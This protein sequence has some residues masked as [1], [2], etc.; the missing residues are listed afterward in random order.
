MY[1]PNLS[2]PQ[3]EQESSRWLFLSLWFEIQKVLSYCELAW[4]CGN[5]Y[6]SKPLNNYSTTLMAW[7]E[8]WCWTRHYCVDRSE[9]HC[10]QINQRFRDVTVT[11]QATQ[12]GFLWTPTVTDT[13]FWSR[14]HHPSLAPLGLNS[15]WRVGL[16]WDK[17]GM[18]GLLARK[19]RWRRI[20]R[21][22]RSARTLEANT[23][24][25][26]PRLWIFISQ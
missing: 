5:Q 10:K 14:G 23:E 2:R 3:L 1:V 18:G 16:G 25:R 21:M 8:H 19:H 4:L 26:T 13:V 15:G 7:R 12:H 20:S 24:V 11:H 17:T 6:S 9:A 22:K